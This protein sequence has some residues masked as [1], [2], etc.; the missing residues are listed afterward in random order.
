MLASQST[1]ASITSPIH[2][3]F[4][5]LFILLPQSKQKGSLPPLRRRQ[6]IG[7]FAEL[8]EDIHELD[9]DSNK[10]VVF[11]NFSKA[12]QNEDGRPKVNQDRCNRFIDIQFGS[13]TLILDLLADGHGKGSGEH[14]AQYILEV[15]PLLLQKE[16]GKGGRR[17]IDVEAAKTNPKLMFDL[18]EH[19]VAVMVEM[20]RQSKNFNTSGGSTL[21]G[22]LLDPSDGSLWHFNVGDSGL[23][24]IDQDAEGVWSAKKLTK[25]HDCGNPEEVARIASYEKGYFAHCGGEKGDGGN[26]MA[27]GDGPQCSRGIG[28][29]RFEKNGLI[30]TPEFGFNQL[31]NGQITFLASDGILDATADIGED[32]SV[33]A[34]E[35]RL[36]RLVAEAFEDDGDISFV[37]RGLDAHTAEWWITDSAH[38]DFKYEDEEGELQESHYMDDRSYLISQFI[39][40]T[41]PK[42]KAPRGSVEPSSSVSALLA[43]AFTSLVGPLS[44]IACY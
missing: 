7:D 39:A 20:L 14:I 10:K 40:A 33:H 28:D 32:P 25:D 1:S 9:T 23:L 24:L 36:A 37:S 16:G 13:N 38:P 11:C 6:S 35:Q 31:K 26:Y 4:V 29:F 43:S 34:T 22:Y 30:S 5:C 19:A 8:S 17:E 42:R 27:G 18:I 15:L 44:L 21:V 41:G 3:S 12:G 2:S